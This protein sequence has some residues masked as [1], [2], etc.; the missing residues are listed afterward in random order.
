M[1]NIL[2]LVFLLQCHVEV[3]FAKT[4]KATTKISVVAMPDP[5]EG[6]APLAEVDMPTWRKGQVINEWR[7][8]QGSAL[9]LVPIAVKTYPGL[10]A[11]GP[12]S[13]V[14]AWNSFVI[15][16]RNSFV[17]SPAN[18]GHNDYAG[19]EVDRIQ[20]EDG[21]PSWTEIRASTPLAQIVAGSHYLDGRPSSRHTFYGALFNE[22][23]NR[24]I[25]AKGA[26]YDPSGG[27][28]QA[29]DGF[30]VLTNDW[31]TKRTYPD[32]PGE[33]FVA[34]SAYVSNKSTGDI[35]TFNNFGVFK[36]T[37]LTNTWSKRR[38]GSI[39]GQYAASAHDSKRN[40]IL[41]LGGENNDRGIYDIAQNTI[42][43]IALGGT[44]AGAVGGTG[45]GMVY[46]DGLDAFV[47]TKG[48]SGGAVYR[49]DP[50]TFSV[51]VLATT[52]GGQMPA[53]VAN[54]V[55]GRFLYAP[56]LKGI[57]YCPT[58]TGNMWFLRTH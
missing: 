27:E 8:I 33:A 45:S 17:Y 12:E 56:R 47:Y 18:G 38:D 53:T 30:N 43:Q 14:T 1:R 19:N 11:T 7:Q 52:G 35:Y 46:V 9:A 48:A 34:A 28:H 4:F 36:W 24:I 26:K 22:Q 31:D 29:V 6:P 10:G 58:Y 50:Q 5:I 57:I 23:R 20:L 25:V 16:T 2:A 32:Q 44:S 37:N 39:Y 42:Q 13:K 3:C 21:A 51:T 55:W 15:D 40:R 49:I 41:V 54:G